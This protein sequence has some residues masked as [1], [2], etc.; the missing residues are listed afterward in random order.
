MNQP[1][2]QPGITPAQAEKHRIRRGGNFCGV[3]LLAMLAAEVLI[4]IVLGVLVGFGAL[5]ASREDYGLGNTGYCLLNM[6]VYVLFLAVPTLGVAA[7]ARSRVQ[8]F[9]TRWVAPSLFLCLLLAGMAMAV[10]SNVIANY[11]MLF[12]EGFGVQMP[13]FTDTVE[14]TPLSLAL[15]V[16]STAMLPALIEEMIFR[17]YLMGTLRP[18][19]DGAAL[20]LSAFIFGLFHGNVLQFPFAFLLGLV[21][22]W[23]LIQTGSIWPAVALHFGNN[24]M[25][26]L[27]SYFAKG[28]SEETDAAVTTATFALISAAG[29]VAIGALLIKDRPGGTGRRDV[30]RPVGN[31]ASL[32]SVRRRVGYLLTSPALVLALIAMIALLV[33]NTEVA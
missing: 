13:V 21:L 19:G 8:P 14:Y 22:G 2:T 11:C 20:V 5:D 29:I 1:W 24:L 30:L 10:L 12:L 6:L 26:V 23:L 27:L 31:G 3:V 33:I 18:Y 7:I 32:F 15:N 17:G 16:I 9:P 25:S 28:Y 4:G